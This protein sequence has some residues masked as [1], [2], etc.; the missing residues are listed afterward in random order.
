MPHHPPV[1]PAPLCPLCHTPSPIPLTPPALVRGSG[2]RVLVA[3]GEVAVV[4]LL[5]VSLELAGYKVGL[6]GSFGEAVGRLEGCELA[7][8]DLGLPGLPE[9]GRPAVGRTPPVLYLL[10]PERLDVILPALDVGERDY[11]TTPLRVA[12]V[13]ARIR[14]LL[15]AAGPARADRTLGYDDLLLDDATCRAVRAGRPLDLTP[16]EYR[17]LRHFLVNAHRVLSKEQISRCVWGDFREG[18]AIE[19]LVSRLRRKV[20]QGARPLLHTR[21]GFGYWLGRTESEC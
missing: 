12:E 4:E 8:V 13:L 7:V 17:L 5:A 14:V 1:A 20:D 3:A 2:Q 9:R 10:P 21:R 18:N 19:Q 11:V 15:R 6:A 16:A